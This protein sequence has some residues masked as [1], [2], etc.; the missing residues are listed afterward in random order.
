MSIKKNFFNYIFFYLIL[1]SCSFNNAG[2]IWT[3]ID[4]EKRKALRILR[5]QSDE[6]IKVYSSDE[7]LP[8]VEK[9]RIKIVS[10]TKPFENR[11]WTMTGLNHQNNSGNLFTH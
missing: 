10:L 9:K 8:S 5:E 2:S 6:V 1:T 3:G 7:I 4:E 11:S